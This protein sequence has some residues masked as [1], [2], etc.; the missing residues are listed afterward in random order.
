MKKLLFLL[1]LPIFIGCSDDDGPMVWD[2]NPVIYTIKIHDEQGVNL[3]DSTVA[4]NWYR[5][6]FEVLY[7]D[8]TY[9]VDWDIGMRWV[10]PVESRLYM[11]YFY[12]LYTEP[13]YGDEQR[14]KIPLFLEFGEFD[15]ARD[16][17]MKIT[18]IVPE[19]NRSYEMSLKR[20]VKRNKNDTERIV[21]ESWA[22][23][24]VPV[25]EP[26]KLVL[27]HRQQ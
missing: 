19:L 15:G 24:G 22:L 26:F 27:P 11:P 5:Y 18:F 1:L 16:Q 10:E 9:V 8:M 21:T 7:E 2:M 23:D 6:D 25:E 12:G 20:E 17:D 4:G 14:I 13:N 3:L